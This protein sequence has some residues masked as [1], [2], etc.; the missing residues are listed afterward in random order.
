MEYKD[1][2]H[3]LGVEKDATNAE[4]KKAYRQ[5]AKR[6]HPDKNAGDKAAEEKFKEVNEAFEVLGDEEKRKKYDRFGAT[7][8]FTDGMDFDPNDFASAFGGFSGFG[9]GG[10]TYT[11]TSTDGGDFSDFLNEIFGGGFSGGRGGFSTVDMNDMFGQADGPGRHGSRGGYANSHG[12]YS[13]GYGFSGGAGYQNQGFDGGS[14]GF[15]SGGQSKPRD[16]ETEMEITLQEA[17]QGKESKVAFN[18]GGGRKIVNV[19]IPA[20]ILPGKKIKLKGQGPKDATGTAGDLYIKIKIKDA[21]GTN[22]DNSFRLEGLD[23][24]KKVEVYPWDAYYGIEKIIQTLDGKIKVKI[25]AN[26][27]PGQKIKLGG[28][29]YKDMKG[30]RGSLYI[31]PSIVNPEQLPEEIQKAYALAAGHSPKEPRAADSMP[32]DKAESTAQTKAANGSENARETE[33]VGEKDD[34]AKGGKTAG[35]SKFSSRLKK[36]KNDEKRINL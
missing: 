14:G 8:N 28:K 36:R 29:G 16:I 3:V 5:L 9:N 26:M 25:P 22:G 32:A 20:G 15:G 2:Y 13:G 21:D 19:K 23:L 31:E 12:S 4:I 30:N 35:G 10:T 7:G 33:N 11:Y 34:S 24:I 18:T 1:F 17:F 6:Y 27:K